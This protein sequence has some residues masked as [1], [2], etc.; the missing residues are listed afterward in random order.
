[1]GHT[2]Y[3]WNTM[4]MSRSRGETSRPRAGSDT[5]RSPIEMRPPVGCSSPATQRKV[6]VLPQPEG[7]SSTTIS[8]AGTSKLTPS[9]AGRIPGA[10]RFSRSEIKRALVTFAPVSSL[11]LRPRNDTLFALAVLLPIP[12]GLV[13]LPEPAG[14]QLLE[15]VELR[16]PHL[17]HLGVP[18]LGEE[19]RLL[20]RGDVSQALDGEGLAL[21]A[22]APVH[23]QP[24]RVRAL[25]R[26]GDAVGVGDDRHALGREDRLGRRPLDDLGVDDVVEQRRDRDL[27]AHQRVGGRS[28]GRI[29]RNLQRRVLLPIVLAQHLALEH[30][31]GPGRAARRADHLADLLALVV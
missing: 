4:P 9:T 31:A 7:P 17:D 27:A 21:L 6:V 11:G 30:D 2:A 12:V 29:E 24:G 22:E 23:E 15:L 13:P 3:D 8:P 20:E 26:L 25:R 5:T 1:C 19:R 28:T 18:A 16:H 14:T 10:N